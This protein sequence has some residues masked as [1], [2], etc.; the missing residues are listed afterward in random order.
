MT[1]KSGKFLA[2]AVLSVLAFV[3]GPAAAAD[4]FVATGSLQDGGRSIHAAV[5]LADGRVLVVGGYGL[6]NGGGR[7]SAEVYDPSNG[8]WSLAGTTSVGRSYPTASLLPD[9]RVLVAGGSNFGSAY[10]ST[11]IWNPATSSFTA[12]PSMST[13]RFAHV[14]VT[15]ADGRVIAIG[16]NPNT[17]GPVPT[18]SAE[19]YDPVTNAWSATGSLVARRQVHAAV[20]LL[21]G[22]VLVV[23]GDEGAANSYVGTTTCQLYDPATETFTLAASMAN[24][25]SNLA[26][27]LLSDGRVLAVGGNRN[28]TGSPIHAAEVYDPVTN[29]WSS[30]G[31][32]G[33]GGSA[34]T[35][36]LLADG[37]ALATGGVD[38]TTPTASADLFDPVTSTFSPAGTM[39]VARYFHSATRLADDS[40]LL[41][42]GYDDTAAFWSATSELFVPDAPPIASPPTANAGPDQS[43]HAGDTVYLDGTDSSDDDTATEDLLYLWTLVALPAGSTATLQDA[44]TATPSFT[45]DEPGTY[46]VSLVVVDDDLLASAADTV[47]ISSTNLAPTTDAGPDVVGVVGQATT[48]EGAALDPEGDDIAWQW[49][50]VSAPAGSA[51]SLTNDTT[52]TASIMPDVVG[53]YVLA[54]VASDPYA[55][56]LADTMSL[57][58]ISGEDFA[59]AQIQAA[60]ETIAGLPTCAFDSPGHRN[61]LSN[62]LASAVNSLRKGKIDAAIGKLESAIARL[63]GCP[64]RG[65]V[66]G[67][68]PGKDWIVDCDVQEELYPLL[69]DALDAL[70]P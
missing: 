28:A 35:L 13:A 69:A 17:D 42:G 43:I 49:T 30:A 45:A 21:N 26:L 66:D 57:T 6:S 14:A 20:R 7:D 4:E 54:L 52:A 40:V 51:A 27:A 44:H 39:G 9:G 22:K 37:R 50:I 16:G 8:S 25:R 18:A 48:L 56:S 46:V 60:S 63:D 33:S 62:L 31:T 70:L 34:P 2:I 12:G 65:D 41:A 10:A 58:A 38:G 64:L 55:S 47:A 61:A 5:H 59:E 19:I 11:E 24:P 3:A 53:V 32:T 36:T 23:G 29:A 67:P 15:L 68:G 1:C